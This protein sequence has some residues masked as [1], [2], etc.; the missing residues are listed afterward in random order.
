MNQVNKLIN[1]IPVIEFTPQ[2]IQTIGVFFLIHGHTCSKDPMY[3]GSFPQRL[4]DLGYVVIAIDAYK[5]GSRIDEP[6]LTGKDYEKTMAMLEVI[7][8][9][10]IDLKYLYENVY[11][12]IGGKLGFLGISMGGHIVFQ[13]PKLISKIDFLVP[14]IGSPDLKRHYVEM[15]SEI[16]N[17]KRMNEL[18]P[19]FSALKNDDNN[20]NHEDLMY[21]IEGKNDLIVS[22]KNAYDFYLR[23]KSKGYNNIEYVDFPVGHVVT[24][25]MENDVME[26]IKNHTML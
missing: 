24:K 6:Y 7:Q 14:I 4:T 8:K 10:C 1:Q 2:N 3:F 17:P 23:M 25:E 26:Y 16:I 12:K 9:T 21:I 11:H 19:Y 13:M 5:H 18:E 15:K 22:Y 20:Y